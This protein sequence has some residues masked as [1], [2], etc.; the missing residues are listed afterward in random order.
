MQSTS[1]QGPV[2]I[3]IALFSFNVFASGIGSY[4]QDEGSAVRIDRLYESGKSVYYAK[5]SGGESVQY[6]IND[7]GQVERVSRRTLKPFVGSSVDDLTARLV[8]CDDAENPVSQ[9]LSQDEVDAVMYYLNKRY[10][11]SLYQS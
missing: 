6:C 11:L 2:A 1:I 4:G 10:R 7:G 8:R 3:L 9:H 5:G